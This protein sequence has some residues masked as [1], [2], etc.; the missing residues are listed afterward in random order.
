VNNSFSELLNGTD[1]F[2]NYSHA[3]E[4]EYNEAVVAGSPEQFCLMDQK[5]I[6][7]PTGRDEVE[8]CDIFSREKQIIHVKRYRGSATLSHLFSQGVVS[9]ELFCGLREFREGVNAHLPQP[10]RISDLGSHPGN[11]EYEVVFAIVSKS[12]NPLTLP[13][14]SRVNLR[15]AAQRLRAFGY[16]ASVVKVQAVERPLPRTASNAPDA[17]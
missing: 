4:E 11:N 3:N 16:K 10:F 13:F 15:N 17:G 7:Y 5:F 6:R 8:F 9:A 2:P 14:F 12:V 1:G